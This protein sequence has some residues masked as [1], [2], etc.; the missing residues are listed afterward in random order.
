MITICF[1]RRSMSVMMM[2][3][4]S[5]GRRLRLKRLALRISMVRKLLWFLQGREIW[6]MVTVFVLRGCMVLISRFIVRILRAVLRWSHEKIFGSG[7]T[8]SYHTVRV[9]DCGEVCEESDIGRHAR[10]LSCS[11]CA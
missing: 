7:G 6:C 5:I 1:N 9:A 4:G 10:V 2:L 8:F 11:Y 3:R